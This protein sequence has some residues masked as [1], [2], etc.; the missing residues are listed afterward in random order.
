MSE[1][2]E[3]M[4]CGNAKEMTTAR[5]GVGIKLELDI[6]ELGRHLR[7]GAK[8]FIREWTDRQGVRHRTIKLAIWPMK[9]ENVTEY[10][11]HSV[12]IDTWKPDPA[13]AKRHQDDTAQHAAEAFG[14]EIVE[15][16]DECPF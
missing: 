1:H 10:R 3:S 14:G 7:E 8:E 9:P 5:G 4:Y 15:D 16:D 11:T 12:K 13:K 2:N 6:D